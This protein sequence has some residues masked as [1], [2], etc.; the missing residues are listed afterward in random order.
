MKEGS[1]WRRERVGAGG[2]EIS[3]VESGGWNVGWSQ[4][5]EWTEFIFGL[6]PLQ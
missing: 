4:A 5:L 3:V 1:G 6:H 2:A